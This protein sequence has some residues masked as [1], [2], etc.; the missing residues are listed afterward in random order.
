MLHFIFF[1]T[2]KTF[3][4]N[5]ICYAMFTHNL[6]FSFFSNKFFYFHLFISW[7][8]YLFSNR[9]FFLY[10]FADADFNLYA[11]TNVLNIP[12]H[13]KRHMSH[14]W[15]MLLT[16]MIN[17]VWLPYTAPHDP[18]VGHV[19]L[20]VLDITVNLIIWIFIVN[21]LTINS[22]KYSDIIF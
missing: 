15:A 20:N 10:N 17:W 18:L 11:D 8:I 3:W 14:R 6:F 5:D 16:V 21:Q 1:C 12:R 7:F 9:I 4:F 13:V 22:S 19:A 2:L